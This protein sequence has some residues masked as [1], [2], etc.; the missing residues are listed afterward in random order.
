MSDILIAVKTGTVVVDGGRR[1]V[2][3]GETTA[4]ASH[5]IVEQYPHL[6]GPIRVDYPAPEARSK[7]RRKDD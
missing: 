4:H 7:R 2:R 5:P 3:K 6:W 1:I